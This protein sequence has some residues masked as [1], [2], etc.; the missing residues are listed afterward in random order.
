MCTGISR[1]LPKWGLWILLGIIGLTPKDFESLCNSVSE[2]L[3]FSSA[4]GHT[5]EY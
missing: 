1:I 5:P 3:C 4:V 2:P